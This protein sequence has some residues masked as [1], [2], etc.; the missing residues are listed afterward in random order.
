MLRYVVIPLASNVNTL[1]ENLVVNF[2]CKRYKW[3]YRLIVPCVE[4]PWNY[5][6]AWMNKSET[7]CCMKTKI[8]LPICSGIEQK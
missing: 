4:F 1:E 8:S 6:T 2:T 3:K 5:A 7:N